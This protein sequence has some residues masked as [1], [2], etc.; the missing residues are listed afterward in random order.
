MSSLPGTVQGCDR[1]DMVYVATSAEIW[2]HK[3]RRGGSE[4]LQ[5]RPFALK[6]QSFV[7]MQLLVVSG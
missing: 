3:G 2:S 6:H 1:D 7:V 5:D 4:Q